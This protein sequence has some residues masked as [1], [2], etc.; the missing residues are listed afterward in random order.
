MWQ[1]PNASAISM[2]LW[3]SHERPICAVG[4]LESDIEAWMETRAA[5]RGV[6][7]VPEAEAGREPEPDHDAS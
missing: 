2:K 5:S 3:D 6:Q 4:W 7:A 1:F